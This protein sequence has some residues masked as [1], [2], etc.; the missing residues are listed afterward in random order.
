LTANTRMTCLYVIV[1]SREALASG[2][3]AVAA[4]RAPHRRLHAHWRRDGI[5]DIS[6]G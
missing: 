1:M 2:G 6:G 4:D 3:D 5:F